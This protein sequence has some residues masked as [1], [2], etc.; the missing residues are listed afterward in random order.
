MVLSRAR[1]V[2]PPSWRFFWSSS[3]S[4]F[5][6]LLDRD[7]LPLCVS[8][9][10]S[11]FAGGHQMYHS[12]H[13]QEEVTSK[14]SASADQGTRW[15]KSNL[16]VGNLKKYPTL[17]IGYRTETTGSERA[18]G[19]IGIN[20][21]EIKTAETLKLLGVTI[22]SRLNFSE[23]ANSAGKEASQSIAVLMRLR[24][25]IPIKAKLQLYKVA[26]LPHLTYCHLV[27]HVC[28]ASDSRKLERLQE[29]GLIVVYNE[30]QGS[31]SSI[32]GKGQAAKFRRHKTATV[33]DRGHRSRALLN[34]LGSFFHS[35][36][37]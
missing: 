36:T 28:R 17:N 13:N 23:H 29:R 12:D 10:I 8:T 21:V 35:L 7:D 4:S 18:S 33:Y 27:W 26:V 25:L 16:Q 20:N 37:F 32:I 15:Y 3:S 5:V 31:L 9:D 14:L 1:V 6:K 2:S 11:M 22:D 30:K 24:K 19:G 34:L